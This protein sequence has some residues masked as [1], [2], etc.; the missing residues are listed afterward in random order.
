MDLASL[1]LCLIVTVVLPNPFSL[2]P[3]IVRQSQV[4]ALSSAHLHCRKKRALAAGNCP[5][6]ASQH[7]LRSVEEKLTGKRIFQQKG[8]CLQKWGQ[9]AIRQKGFLLCH[10]M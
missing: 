9:D 1:Q 7:L 8:T 10:C 6:C 2:P 3:P 4:S 5:W